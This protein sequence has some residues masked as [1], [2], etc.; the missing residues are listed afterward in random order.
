[1]GRQLTAGIAMALAACTGVTRVTVTPEQLHSLAG[2]KPNEERGFR[3][4]GHG[5]TLYARGTD[6]VR[7]MIETGTPPRTLDTSWMQLSE[8]QWGARPMAPSRESAEETL[9]V[10]AEDVKGADVRLIRYDPALTVGLAVAGFA[11]AGLVTA[12]LVAEANQRRVIV[13][14]R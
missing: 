8:L 5:E 9:H 6:E 10:P 14:F 4:E 12:F 2:L 7:L 11:I 1:V 3:A 13:T